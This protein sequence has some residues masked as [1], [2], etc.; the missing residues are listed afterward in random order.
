[1]QH[2]A[3]F[4]SQLL[5]GLVLRWHGRPRQLHIWLLP[6][7]LSRLHAI[8]NM[9]MPNANHWLIINAAGSMH[10]TVHKKIVITM[11]RG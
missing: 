10:G 5:S 3:A 9:H 1:M 11:K 2:V 7:K 8:Y 4:V 6:R